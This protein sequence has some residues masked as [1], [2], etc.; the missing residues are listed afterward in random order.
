M[1]PSSHCT[2]ADI[3]SN[4]GQL[5]RWHLGNTEMM[6]VG[7]KSQI[8]DGRP[9]SILNDPVPVG[10]DTTWSLTGHQTGGSYSSSRV[11]LCPSQCPSSY[12][13]T[14]KRTNR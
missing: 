1:G 4:A 3:A 6:M 9:V 5:D 7:G 2:A 11:R 8:Q 14:S 10:V 12:S 13:S